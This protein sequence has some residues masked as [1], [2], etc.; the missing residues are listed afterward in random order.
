MIAERIRKIIHT[1][2]QGKNAKLKM[3]A[4]R[5]KKSIQEHLQKKSLYSRRRSEEIASR[6]TRSIREHIQH[7]KTDPLIVQ[8][9][10]E[11]ELGP[12]QTGEAM[13][14]LNSLP[15]DGEKREYLTKV[16]KLPDLAIQKIMAYIETMKKMSS[17]S[18]S[19]NSRPSTASSGSG[20]P[21]SAPPGGAGG[22]GGPSSAPPGGA[23]GSGGPSSAPPGGGG[24]SSRGPSSAPPSTRM[25]SLI[26]AAARTN[27][28]K[29]MRTVAGGM[30]PTRWSSSAPPGGGVSGNGNNRSTWRK[31]VNFL[32]GLPGVPNVIK[33]GIQSD[34]Y[35]SITN[36]ANAPGLS[37]EDKIR[38][39]KEYLK[40]D[41]RSKANKL[42]LL[43]NIRNKNVKSAL[44][45]HVS[46]LP[47]NVNSNNSRKLGAISGLFK[48]RNSI[49]SVLNRKNLNNDQKAILLT[50]ALRSNSRSIKQKMNMISKSNLSSNVK[51]NLLSM[52]SN[53]NENQRERNYE[54]KELNRERNYERKELNRE[55]AYEMRERQM[56]LRG[57]G[58]SPYYNNNRNINYRFP[59]SRPSQPMSP[60]RTYEPS[61]NF[62]S[63]RNMNMN[64]N[65]NMGGGNMNRNTI[66]GNR[67]RNTVVGNRNRNRNTVVGNR[68]RN[69]NTVVGNNKMMIFNNRAS[70]KKTKSSRPVRMKL[71]KE[72][73]DNVKKKKLIKQIRKLGKK[74]FEKIIKQSK[75]KIVKYIVKEIRPPAKKTK[76]RAQSPQRQLKENQHVSFKNTFVSNDTYQRNGLLIP[77]QRNGNGNQGIRPPNAT[78]KK[79]YN[80][81]PAPFPS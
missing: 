42:R 1:H 27:I 3:I 70:T 21:S 25:S 74:D 57:G 53:Q 75:S 65:R 69:R 18:T 35:K 26:N 60:S 20:G 23:G 4:E 56:R 67:N 7:I 16:L 12:V 47:N 2:L 39:L 14:T 40:A 68:N 76:K 13:R 9:I 11:T 29:F 54:R 17:S 49:M 52:L 38:I 8:R 24:N 78:N 59:I 22:S 51:T 36:F 32:P 44:I 48:S 62:G 58:G 64:R 79:Q 77:R 71:L 50:T 5:I 19:G 46:N 30:V 61:L 33:R 28:G 34:L 73:V 55:R 66:V 81:N 80:Y 43:T 31:F 6:I 63:G 72:T 37:P 10:I 41:K 15:T 45:A